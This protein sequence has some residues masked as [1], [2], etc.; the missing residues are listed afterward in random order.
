MPAVRSKLV[1]SESDHTNVLCF[2]TL[3][4]GCHVEFDAL[5]DVERLVSIALDVGKVNEH[6]VTGCAGDEA[7]ALLGIEELHS[8]CSQFI[9]SLCVEP[10]R[11]TDS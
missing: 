1:T 4:T 8:T 3:A 10:L 7:E 9:F 6:V 11:L 2:F 5:T